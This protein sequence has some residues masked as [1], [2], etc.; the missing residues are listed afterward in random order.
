MSPSSFSASLQRLVAMKRRV[1]IVTC[2]VALVAACAALYL[3]RHAPEREN[4]EVW[5]R[6]I[7][8]GHE[9]ALL[10]NG[11]YTSRTFCDICDKNNEVSGSWTSDRGRII[12]KQVGLP[13]TLERI[14]FKGCKALVA[15]EGG[16]GDGEVSLKDLYF[17]EHDP[18]AASL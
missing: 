11:R 5:V 8:Y 2:A 17:R 9:I 1:L 13:F 10:T 18:C 14:D 3:H 12:L 15:R 7:G 4:A 6:G 16:R